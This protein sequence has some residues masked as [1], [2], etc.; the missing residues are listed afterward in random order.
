MQ[1]EIITVALLIAEIFRTD[2]GGVCADSHIMGEWREADQVG[3][4]RARFSDQRDW[5]NWTGTQGANASANPAHPAQLLAEPAR[6]LRD[7]SA[8]LFFV[9]W[10]VELEQWLIFWLWQ[11]FSF[12][13]VFIQQ[14]TVETGLSLPR[15]GTWL[16]W[17]KMVLVNRSNPITSFLETS[18]AMND[19]T[20]L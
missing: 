19:S 1:L 16:C 15:L 4:Y 2:G 18:Q 8:T 11:L 17:M 14:D 9:A 7:A 12:G 20:L 10:S 5:Q 6:H 13:T 3:R